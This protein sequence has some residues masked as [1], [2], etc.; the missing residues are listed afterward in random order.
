MSSL[1]LATRCI[2]W[3]VPPEFRRDPD[4]FR[5]ASMFVGAHLLGPPLGHLITLYLLIID[6]H[7]G[8]HL[9][10]SFISLGIFYPLPLLLR[11]TGRFAL[12]SHIS[13]QN[14]IFVVLFTAF[15]YGGVNSP[16]LAWL[17]V[18]PLLAFFYVG[19]NPRALAAVIVPVAV[20]L[21]IG[22]EMHLQGYSFPEHVPMSH[23]VGMG[24]FSIFI[25][26]VFVSSLSF[27]Y[28]T[29]MAQAAEMTI[30]HQRAEYERQQAEAANRAKSDFLAKMSHELRTPLNSVLGF[31]QLLEFNAR[32]PLS[33]K[34]ARQV[35]QIKKS[36]EHLLSLI[37][38]VLDL[39]KIES[40]NIRLSLERVALDSLL[41]EVRSTL[42]ALAE[43][44]QVTFTVQ[45]APGT[46]SVRADR[47]R[48]AQ[49]L[50]NLGTN[51]IKYNRPGGSATL[52]AE[53]AGEGVVRLSM[54]DT[55]VGIPFDRQGDVFEPFNR[56]GA[57]HG[58]IEGTGIGLTI[59]RKL[60][61]L[62]N[63]SLTFRS[64]P[65]HGSTFTVELPAE[66]EPV[67]ARVGEAASNLA[68]EAMSAALGGRS[69]GCTL[70][71][72]ED[73]PP[74]IALMQA[75]VESLEG[76]RLLI[77]SDAETGLAL[78]RAHRPD[79]I[80][81][82]INLPGMSGFDILERLKAAPATERIPVMAL[83]AA[84]MP[85]EVERGLAAGFT[86]YLTKPI[87][88]PVFLSAIDSLLGARV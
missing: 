2:G 64:E 57:E 51:A 58:A 29:I 32:E 42:H 74:N 14:L 21:G 7:P 73:N 41:D 47:T 43:A 60:A 70:L 3:F 44:A 38:E 16:F 53:R 81:L 87:N 19:P 18:V 48:L 82:D 45:L 28:A 1:G 13:V 9:W 49:I 26:V 31:A 85:R 72:V 78:A 84:A 52:V 71:Y 67:E 17:L 15:E 62:M 36:G 80:I 63:G 68:K 10:P 46:P 20:Y 50:I 37:D 24:I 86:H 69:G 22:Y 40:G 65:G 6:P 77:A 56:L 61:Q 27:Y 33:A 79:V 83:T 8:W 59:S 25:G 12:I 4:K 35:H 23:M 54:I 55:G 66:S 34:Q 39:S 88:V 11:V 75:L 76:V 5:R 30:A